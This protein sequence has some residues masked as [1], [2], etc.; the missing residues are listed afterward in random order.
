MLGEPYCLTPALQKLALGRVFG[1]GD[2]GVV[3][4]G[5]L[6]VAAQAPEQVGT[7]RVEQVI[8]IEIEAVDERERRMRSVDFGHGDRAVQ[9]DDRAR[10]DRHELVVELQDLPPVRRGRGR[11]RRCGRR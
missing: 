7:D 6:G 8:A 1:A 11:A 10:R 4:Q 9:R 3:R 5:G 2:R